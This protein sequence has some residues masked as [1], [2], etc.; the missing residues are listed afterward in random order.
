MSPSPLFLRHCVP[1]LQNRAAFGWV[2]S[3]QDWVFAENLRTVSIAAILVTGPDCIQVQTARFEQE[4][5]LLQY[6]R[7]YHDGWTTKRHPVAEFF[8]L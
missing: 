3:C 8:P 6:S 1:R 2:C 7:Y 4:K 5:I